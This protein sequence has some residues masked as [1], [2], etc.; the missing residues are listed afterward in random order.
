[1]S[2]IGARCAVTAL[3]WR[4]VR[5]ASRRPKAAKAIESTPSCRSRVSRQAARAQRRALESPSRRRRFPHRHR[6]PP[7]ARAPP[8]RIH[9]W[10]GSR[11]RGNFQTLISLGTPIRIGRV[12]ALAALRRHR[13]FEVRAVL[14]TLRQS[15]GAPGDA[16]AHKLARCGCHGAGRA[17]RRHQALD[18]PRPRRRRRTRAAGHADPQPVSAR[19]CRGCAAGLSGRRLDSRRRPIGQLAF[20]PRFTSTR[21]GQHHTHVA[22]R[23]SREINGG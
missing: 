16:I 20:Q 9:V 14:L 15:A 1:M 17:M 8:R 6:F 18:L 13:G 23:R 21:S 11:Q 4:K 12:L 10:P 19:R 3:R 22:E 2:S 7:A 5:L